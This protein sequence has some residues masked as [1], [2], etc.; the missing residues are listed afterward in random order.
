MY[1]DYAPWELINMMDEASS[2]YRELRLAA[3]SEGIDS[4]K[5][6]W[7]SELTCEIAQMRA[8]YSEIMGSGAFD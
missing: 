7:L 4:P 8:A 5:W 6:D 1:S 3:M 2:Q